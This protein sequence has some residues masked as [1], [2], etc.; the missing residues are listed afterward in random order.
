MSTSFR[1]DDQMTRSWISS[2]LH[3]LGEMT[4]M[5]RSWISSYLIISSRRDDQ[6]WRDPG[7]QIIVIWSSLLEE[8]LRHD[9]DL[10]HLS[11]LFSSG[12]HSLS[13]HT[14]GQTDRSSQTQRLTGQSQCENFPLV[15]SIA[16]PF[17]GSNLQESPAGYSDLFLGRFFKYFLPD[18]ISSRE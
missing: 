9:D 12:W 14:K 8:I 3:P 17:T 18:L 16:V 11:H 4:Q 13:F 6:T 1:R 7:S 5:T 10:S 2:C 15:I